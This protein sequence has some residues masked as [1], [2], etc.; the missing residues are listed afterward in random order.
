V[1]LRVSLGVMA[2][3]TAIGAAE[4]LIQLAQTGDKA[5][6]LY[7]LGYGWAAITCGLSALPAPKEGGS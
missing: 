1:I 7:A 2:A 5:M 4:S 3:Y 6:A